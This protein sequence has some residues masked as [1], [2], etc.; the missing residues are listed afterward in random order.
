MTP[1]STKMAYQI[2]G[3]PS[4]CVSADLE[5]IPSKL[6]SIKSFY[7]FVDSWLMVKL[8]LRIGRAFFTWRVNTK[9]FNRETFWK[10]FDESCLNIPWRNISGQ[11]GDEHPAK[12]PTVKRLLR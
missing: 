7:K 10:E 8:D 6:Y 5:G 4:F 12:L 11:V 3:A 2:L 1:N 9:I